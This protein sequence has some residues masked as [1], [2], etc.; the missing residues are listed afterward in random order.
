[1]SQPTPWRSLGAGSP[2][3]PYQ[4]RAV[5]ELAA[6]LAVPGAR[7]CLV[8]PPG[9]GK[10]RCA[11]HV[12]VELGLPLEVR[13]PTTQLVQQWR[14]RLAHT[15][16]PLDG[17]AGAAP[18][19]VSTYAGLGTFA[20]GA[21][22]VLD[23]AHHLGGSWGAQ[24]EAAL[25][26]GHRVLGLTATPPEGGAGWERFL[27]LVGSAPVQV[28]VPPLVRDGHLCPYQD[29]VWPVLAEA[30]EVPE[31]TAALGALSQAE[32]ALG[33]ALRQ[34]V[35][36]Q[37]RE[38]LWD[39]TEARFAGRESLLVSLCRLR[40]AQ[41]SPLPDDLPPDPELRAPP[42]LQDRVAVLWAFDPG[43]PEVRQAVEAA[44]FAR[45]G[46]GLRPVRDV[47]LHSLSAAGARI[48]GALDIL[49]QVADAR[50]LLA[51]APPSSVDLC[52]TSPPYW[53]MASVP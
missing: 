53:N 26:P 6:A 45:R 11:I 48:R 46:K 24:V 18:V 16:V 12:A 1:M 49:A 2:L 40:H 5:A 9:A 38:H 8:A 39:L 13:V 35:A 30:A 19:R 14:Q 32:E 10:T 43:R 50:E 15:L 21:L 3:R 42:T 29:L 28:E 52:I 20:D 22:V 23:E 51:Y 25:G 17:D 7:A 33:E 41:G 34:W 27:S 31:L 37:L 4:R 36:W 47:A 44:G